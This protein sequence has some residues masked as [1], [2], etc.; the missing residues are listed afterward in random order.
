MAGQKKP[1]PDSNPNMNAESRCW[2][3]GLGHGSVCSTGS[4]GLRWEVLNMVL[5]R[6]RNH[7]VLKS[8]HTGTMTSG[9]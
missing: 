8:K 3:L 7:S 2:F 5:T 9:S 4:Q 1:E 6:V